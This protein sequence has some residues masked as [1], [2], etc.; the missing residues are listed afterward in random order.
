MAH[1]DNLNPFLNAQKQVK[2]A[3]DRLGLEADVYEL[4][5]QPMKVLEVAIPVKMDDGSVKVFTGYRAMHNDAVGPTKGGIRFHPNVNRDEVMALSIWMTFKCCVTGIPYGGGKGGVIV[6]PSTLSKGELERLSRGYIDATYKL[7][8]EKVDVP[9]PDVG[10][11]GQ[12]MAWMVDEYCKLVGKSELGVITGKPV[13]YGG[14]KGRTAATGFGVA[15]TAREA[16]K[17]L[18]IE[19][20][21]AK[22]ALQGI[23][24][25][26]S[27]TGYNLEK[28][29]GKIIAVCE[30]N[31]SVYDE[32]GLDMHAL[33]DYMKKNKKI[34]GFPG[35]KEITK[36]EFFALP[37]D[38]LVPAAL[39]NEITADVAETIQ[40]KFVCEAA[41]G[42]T[43]PD[44]DEVL[45]R[46]GILLTPDILTN[47]GGV[48]VSY[49]EWV[50][51]L[52]GY[53]WGE[54]EV[55]Q[56]EEIAMVDAFNAIY[57]IKEEYNVPMRTAAYMHSVKKVAAAMKVRG[58][59]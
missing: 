2:E 21:G 46:K 24:N 15:V 1:Q 50:Q 19:F 10:T 5:K 12:V 11:N 23:G 38:I 44:G 6:D 26:G 3:C 16:A 59:Y 33:V 58:W 36:Q 41:N 51:N 22:I 45:A 13:E 42:P 34:V 32:N 17:K 48:T 20:K 9:A 39:E 30:W 57:K 55:E 54:E 27:H 47:A 7:L 29:G 35:S 14:S 18:G 40:A 49:F 52:Y 4:L 56:K 25:V 37:V 43:T 31:G 53:Y 28:L 8:G